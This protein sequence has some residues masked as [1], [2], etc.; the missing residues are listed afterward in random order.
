M[1]VSMLSEQLVNAGFSIEVFATT[2]N[3]KTELNVTPGQP[4]LVDGVWVRYFKRVTKDHS[5]FSP[6]LLKTLWKEVK[7]V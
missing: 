3:G 1:S 5:H 2:A 7:K 6:A 4:T